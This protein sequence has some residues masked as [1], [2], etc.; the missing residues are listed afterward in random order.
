MPSFDRKIEGFLRLFE[1][2]NAGGDTGAV[3]AQFADVFLAAGPQGTQAVRASDFALALPRRKER[4][5]A[6]GCKSTRLISVKETPL[7][8]RYVMAQTRWEFCFAVADRGNELVVVDSV[9]LIDAGAAPYRIVFYL[10]SQDIFEVLRARGI[11]T[12][13]AGAQP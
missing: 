5:D 11:G 1:R 7:D 9:F 6:L 8:A 2:N 13:G 4:F 12:D 10:A 3:V